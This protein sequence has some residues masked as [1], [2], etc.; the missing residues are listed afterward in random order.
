MVDE[1]DEL[2]KA[3]DD[4]HHSVYSSSCC[5]FQ[6]EYNLSEQVEF[7]NIV[8]ST[9]HCLCPDQDNLYF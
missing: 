3:I 5:F 8:S 9:R 6:Y 7:Q 2:L 1:K 4:F